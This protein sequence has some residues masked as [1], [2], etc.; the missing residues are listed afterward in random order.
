M[1]DDHSCHRSRSGMYFL[2]NQV[3][4]AFCESK[5]LVNKCSEA[6]KINCS[7]HPNSFI[8]SATHSFNY[9]SRKGVIQLF[10]AETVVLFLFSFYIDDAHQDCAL[11]VSHHLMSTE[12]RQSVFKYVKA[13]LYHL[14]GNLLERISYVQRDL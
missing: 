4:Q 12:G 7:Y 11:D 5:D 6:V 1:T 14:Q 8:S 2:L 10:G 13:V 3:L 9:I